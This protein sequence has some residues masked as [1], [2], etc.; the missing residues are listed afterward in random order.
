MPI[1]YTNCLWIFSLEFSHNNLTENH[2]FFWLA[3]G[4]LLI[5]CFYTT[6]LW[7]YCSVTLL[8][9]FYESNPH[10][11][12]LLYTSA[13][14]C[15]MYIKVAIGFRSYWSEI[16]MYLYPDIYHATC[17]LTWFCYNSCIL[18][19]YTAQHWTKTIS[20]PDSKWKPLSDKLS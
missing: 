5:N 9:G 20:N 19:T 3:N 6:F 14:T 1:V 13:S 12:I 18:R 8:N 10:Y 7:Y 17:Q 16:Y 15:N 2:T 4:V 11:D